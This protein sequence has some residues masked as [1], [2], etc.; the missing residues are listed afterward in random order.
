MNPEK[1][2]SDQHRRTLGQ[3]EPPPEPSPDNPEQ[4][5]DEDTGDN[6]DP[7]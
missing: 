7:A 1:S 6:E 3:V 4:P 2:E 5:D